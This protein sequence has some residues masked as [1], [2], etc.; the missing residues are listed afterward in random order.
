MTL[1]IGDYVQRRYGRNKAVGKVV[2]ASFDSPYVY[3]RWPGK[4][5]HRRVLAKALVKVDT[6]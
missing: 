4:V 3:V 5:Q 2:I 6:P 1:S